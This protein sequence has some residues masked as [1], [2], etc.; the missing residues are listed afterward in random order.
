MV[1]QLNIVLDWN[2][3]EASTQEFYNYV[4]ETANTHTAFYVGKGN[5]S[6][7]RSRQARNSK[8]G[9]VANKHG[10]IRRVIH[11]TDVAHEHEV[12][13]H[14]RELISELG[15]YAY[16]SELGCNFTRG[17]EGAS[18]YR[19]SPEA[20][21]IMSASRLGKKPSAETCA[22]ISASNRGQKRKPET[23]QKIYGRCSEMQRLTLV[24]ARAARRPWNDNRRQRASEQNGRNRSV[25]QLCEGTIIATHPS[26][27][28]AS[29]STGVNAGSIG[30][31]CRGLTKTAGGFTWRYATSDC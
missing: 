12:L 26:I 8:H 22:R 4:D 31:C 30:Y 7:V 14:E 5:V 29:K 21:A 27:T 11:S 17:G 1:M 18:G 28:S 19:F 10:I 13:Q 25:E 9:H 23:C 16:T 20:K 6:R 2:G 3:L 15:T 24:K